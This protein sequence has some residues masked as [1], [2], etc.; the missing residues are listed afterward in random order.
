MNE[1]IKITLP[2]NFTPRPY[3]INVW[4]AFIRDGIRR[5]F[6]CWHRRS[7]KDLTFFNIL[8]TKAFKR[9]GSYYYYFPTKADGRAILWEGMDKEGIRF[10]DRIPPGLRDGEPKNVEMQVNLK[11]GSNFRV[12]GTDDLRVVGPNPVGCVFSEYSL[13]NPAGWD[14]IRPILAEN[15]GW[16]LFNCTPRGRNHAYRMHLMAKNNPKW[17]HEALTVNDTGAISLEVIQEERVSGMREELI[18]QE[19][20]VS[21]DSAL[22]GAYY[23]DD[24][25]IARSQGRIGQV[26]HDP[27]SPV[28]TAWDLGVRNSMAIWFFQE[29]V[30][31]IRIIDYYQNAGPGLDHYINVLNQKGYEYSEHWAPHDIKVREIGTGVTRL[32]TAFSKGLRFNVCPKIGVDDGIEAV[33]QMFPRLYIDETNCEQGL[34]AISAYRAE[35][36]EKKEILRKVPVH[37][38]ASDGADALRVIATRRK[39]QVALDHGG[40]NKLGRCIVD[41]VAL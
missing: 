21:W 3:Q 25:G 26:P 23:A 10:L 17:F 30:D 39:T 7:G 32:E 27:A 18:Q 31:E 8:V 29:T 13:Q 38:W 14:L 12:M 11:N 33:H 6:C 24:I 35:K 41:K 36:D 28:K 16:A 1:D 9:V 22:E 37:D 34:D 2:Y 4:N 40:G 19:F 15:E 20:F 5:G